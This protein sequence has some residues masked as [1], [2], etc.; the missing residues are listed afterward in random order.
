MKYYSHLELN[1]FCIWEQ[2]EVWNVSGKFRHASR[3]I[4][5]FSLHSVIF[6]NL[7]LFNEAHSQC[8]KS[9]CAYPACFGVHL[10]AGVLNTKCF[11][12]DAMCEV[13]N[14]IATATQCTDSDA[15]RKHPRFARIYGGASGNV[16]ITPE[17][18]LFLKMTDIFASGKCF[19]NQVPEM[20]RWFKLNL[21]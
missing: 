13:I 8:V 12:F 9:P 15:C 1:L 5:A 14:L 4:S 2:R 7:I 16:N 18:T 19:T 17:W 20:Q 6:L 11:L 21:T 3:W 10:Q